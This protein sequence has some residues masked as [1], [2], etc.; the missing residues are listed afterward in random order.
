MIRLTVE[1]L[2]AVFKNP[3]LLF[4][5]HKRT[6][7]RRELWLFWEQARSVLQELQTQPGLD[8]ASSSV[9]NATAF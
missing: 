2:V 7:H 1:Y 8:R 5:H 4:T 6:G 9:A 3:F